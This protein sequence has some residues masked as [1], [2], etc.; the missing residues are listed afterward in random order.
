[1]TL[2]SVSRN[3]SPLFELWSQ[4]GM[5]DCGANR[6]NRP[7]DNGLILIESLT[8]SSMKRVGT[9]EFDSVSLMSFASNPDSLASS[10]CSA[11]TDGQWHEGRNSK[12]ARTAYRND[13]K[14][15]MDSHTAK[16]MAFSTRHFEMVDQGQSE[17]RDITEEDQLN[18]IR[19]FLNDTTSR[20]FDEFKQDRR[21]PVSKVAI[22]DDKLRY[23]R[24]VHHMLNKPLY[25]TGKKW[26]KFLFD[27][28]MHA[29]LKEPCH[30]SLVAMTT[31]TFV[32][33]YITGTESVPTD[34]IFASW[35]RNILPACHAIGERNQEGVYE[36][37]YI[38][39]Q[40][41]RLVEFIFNS[42]LESMLTIDPEGPIK[43]SL[44]LLAVLHAS[45]MNECRRLVEDLTPGLLAMSCDL[46]KFEFDRTGLGHRRRLIELIDAPKACS[47]ILKKVENIERIVNIITYKGDNAD[48]SERDALVRET[49]RLAFELIQSDEASKY[50]NV[51]REV[52]KEVKMV[53]PTTNSEYY[54]Q[55]TVSPR[56]PS[57]KDLH[58]LTLS[59]TTSWDV[60][61]KVV[62]LQR[63]KNE[64]TDQ[65]FMEFGNLF[66]FEPHSVKYIA[67]QFS[68]A[69]IDSPRTTLKLFD[70]TL[71]T[72]ARARSSPPSLI[73]L[74]MPMF[75]LNR[76]SV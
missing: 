29:F 10:K 60:F 17:A 6:D 64:E 3:K 40:T 31:L 23:T 22:I 14:E 36:Y 32:T 46:R 69:L 37:S 51:V 19:V 74:A 59:I 1:M 54:K 55:T 12:T 35:K 15:A 50:E 39:L 68:K 33:A 16:A 7:T 27:A 4:A 41:P 66:N 38:E 71:L 2:W 25:E 47:E 76:Q 24:F 65:F 5:A 63:E 61:L 57:P 67:R 8:H 62:Y 44:L 73:G 42:T 48:S 53:R 72:N 45:M 52:M 20:I 28:S 18:H 58:Y 49:L 34:E 9:R 75:D 21:K 11:Q 30:Q 13:L 70:N 56:T 26:I 43:Q